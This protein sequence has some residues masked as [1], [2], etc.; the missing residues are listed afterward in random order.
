MQSRSK[1]GLVKDEFPDVWRQIH[2]SRNGDIDVSSL[3]CGSDK[4]LVWLC[5]E[6][7]ERRPKGCKCEH[8]WEAWV[9]RRCAK[10]KRHRSGCPFCAGNAVCECLSIAKLQPELMQYWCSS[11]NAELDPKAI[12]P[13]SSKRAWWEHVCVDGYLHR[14]YLLVNGVV[15]RFK[16]TGRF[17]CKYCAGYEQ[18]VRYAKHRARGGLVDDRD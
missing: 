15:S 18:S 7:K 14:R 17:P 8:A 10:V 1:R 12:G 3:T 13:G 16:K 4:K 9:H 11:L 6:N 5:Q 2:P